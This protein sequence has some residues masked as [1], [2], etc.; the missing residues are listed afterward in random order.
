MLNYIP[1]NVLREDREDG[2]ILLSSRVPLGPVVENTGC[3][4][5]RWADEAPDRVFIA[6]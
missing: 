6:E 1:H 2:S 3:W 4:L 5:H